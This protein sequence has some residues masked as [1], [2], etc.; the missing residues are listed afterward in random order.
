M[1]RQ[2]AFD[3]ITNA[4]TTALKGEETINVYK[5]DLPEDIKNKLYSVIQYE[6]KDDTGASFDLSF[7]IM[8]NALS[9][10]NEATFDGLGNVYDNSEFASVYTGEQLSWLT[11]NNQSEIS[12]LSKEF[13]CDIAQACAIWYD[14]AV[15]Q[16]IEEIVS[17]IDSF[18]D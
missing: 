11:I 5:E 1:N 2:E 7:D 6:I 13:G 10:I 12:D 3:I 15:R 9:E 4:M 17:Y 8:Q 16:A 18:E 14:L